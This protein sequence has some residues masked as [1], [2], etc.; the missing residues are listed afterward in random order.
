MQIG[1]AGWLT[2]CLA[3]WLASWQIRWLAGLLVLAGCVAG[4]LGGLLTGCLAGW[5][6]KFAF[7]ECKLLSYRQRAFSLVGLLTEVFVWV[8]HF[9]RVFTWLSDVNE[10]SSK[11]VALP[12][13]AYAKVCIFC[14]FSD[15]KL[16]FVCVFSCKLAALAGWLAGCLAG[17]KCLRRCRRSVFFSNITDSW[18]G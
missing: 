9:E 17:C 13:N 6:G 18:T 3:D 16:C 7:F 15:C 4:W 5:R 12:I 10:C 2:G 8:S 14:T 11:A 1:Y